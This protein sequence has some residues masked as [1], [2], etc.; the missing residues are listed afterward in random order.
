MIEETM[1]I[2]AVIFVVSFS[3]LSAYRLTCR[4]RDRRRLADIRIVERWIQAEHERQYIKEVMRGYVTR[5][6]IT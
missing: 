4:Q 6:R 3:A 5:N 2:I 1:M